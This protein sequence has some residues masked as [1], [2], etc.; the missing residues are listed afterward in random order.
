M[1][2]LLGYLGDLSVHHLLM[3]CHSLQLKGQ[4]VDQLS[5]RFINLGLTLNKVLHKTLQFRFW[6]WGLRRWLIRNSRLKPKRLHRTLRLIGRVPVERVS[7]ALPSKVV[8]IRV[9]IVLW[10]WV[11]FV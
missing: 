3:G 6:L 9:G 11:E 8:R 2:D 1:A 7:V 10:R 4:L 5:K